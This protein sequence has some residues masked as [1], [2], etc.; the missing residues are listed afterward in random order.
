MRRQHSRGGREQ[1]PRPQ[2]QRHGQGDEEASAEPC[3]GTTSRHDD[4]P[5]QPRPLLSQ[6]RR[7]PAPRERRPR[8]RRA[9]GTGPRGRATAEQ[10]HPR[11]RA[12]A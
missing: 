11:P 2:L 5:H 6:H 3:H 8:S 7:C 4:P 9:G 12:P 1:P 10:R